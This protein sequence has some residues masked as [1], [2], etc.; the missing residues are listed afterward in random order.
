MVRRRAAGPDDGAT[1]V[2]RAYRRRVARARSQWRG[3]CGVE[4]EQG[5][6]RIAVVQRTPTSL[7][8]RGEVG[9]RAQRSDGIRV[10]GR[11][12]ESELVA[13]PSPELLCSASTPLPR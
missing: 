9:F 13:L 6:V 7:R 1:D 10:R 5:G 11:F 12:R 3:N 4:G 2:E 8:V